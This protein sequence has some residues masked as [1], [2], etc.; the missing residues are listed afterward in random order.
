MA[1]LSRSDLPG[2]VPEPSM[3]DSVYYVRRALY[4]LRYKQGKAEA[5]RNQIL[6]YIRHRGWPVPGR[7]FDAAVGRLCA[8]MRAQSIGNDVYRLTP[9][10]ELEEE[11]QRR[12]WRNRLLAELIQP[13]TVAKVIIGTAGL[14]AG[15]AI[16]L[17]TQKLL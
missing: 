13:A 10:G 4:E 8:L 2:N 5:T 15:I 16:T 12:P 14:L 3:G 1:R 7:N 17:L 9:D 6:D 11:E